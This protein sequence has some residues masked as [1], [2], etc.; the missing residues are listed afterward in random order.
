[1]AGEKI[2]EL[3][4]GSTPL[5]PPPALDIVKLLDDIQLEQLKSDLRR[6][7]SALPKLQYGTTIE[8]E[9]GLSLTE[10]SVTKMMAVGPDISK[11]QFT[12]E[13]HKILIRLR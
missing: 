5:A 11:F 13:G 8:I 2:S 12:V 6:A 4:K 9:T 1:M 10:A 7:L 3:G